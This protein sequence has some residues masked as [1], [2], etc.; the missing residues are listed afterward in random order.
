V[1]QRGLERALLDI[2]DL[3]AAY[4]IEE[5]NIGHFLMDVTGT[6][7]K[8]RLRFPPDMIIMTK[9]LITAEGSARQLY[10]KLDVISEAEPHVRRIAKERFLP[11]SVWKV[12]RISFSQLLKLQGQL[13]KRL[14]QIIEKIEHG[15]INIRF[16]HE[17]LDGFRK[18]LQN[19][20][21]KLASSIII[22]AMIIGSSMIITTGVKP[23]IFGYP[24]LGILGY[25]ISALIGLW[26]IYDILSSRY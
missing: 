9:A 24:A 13:P 11:G 18:T 6:V 5:L 16:Q 14:G 20:F 21:N 7:R 25:L 15:E 26:L 8:F 2:I 22:G 10:P 19:I 3:Y 12:L 23:H 1:D 17:N 4:P